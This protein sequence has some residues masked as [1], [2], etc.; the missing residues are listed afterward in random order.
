[1]NPIWEP[2]TMIEDVSGGIP[3]FL[4]STSRAKGLNHFIDTDNNNWSGLESDPESI[5][6]ETASKSGFDDSDD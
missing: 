3:R 6:T 2:D 4:S 1:M 5:M